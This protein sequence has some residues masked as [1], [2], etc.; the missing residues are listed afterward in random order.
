MAGRLRVLLAA[1][2][3]TVATVG[4]VPAPIQPMCS[5]GTTSVDIYNYYGDSPIADHHRLD[6]VGD[7]C[8]T[9]WLLDLKVHDFEPDELGLRSVTVFVFHHENGDDSTVLIHRLPNGEAAYFRD[10]VEGG[11]Q[12]LIKGAVPPRYYLPEAEQI[13][14][15]QVPQR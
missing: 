5:S 10:S 6:D 7:M 3:V 12:W 9:V 4:C 11:L 2:A 1:A 8:E 13:D 15:S 14:R